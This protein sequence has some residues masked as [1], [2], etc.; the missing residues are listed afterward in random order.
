MRIPVICVA[1]VTGIPFILS[2]LKLLVSNKQKLFT[3]YLY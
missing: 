1:Q 2:C 3:K